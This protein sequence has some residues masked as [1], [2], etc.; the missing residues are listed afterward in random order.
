MS[1]T[2]TLLLG[3]FVTAVLVLLAVIDV[4]RRIVPNRIVLPATGIVL[5]VR[6]AL[7]PGEAPVYVL[8]ALL[9]AI[10]LFLPRLLSSA[11]IGMGDVKLG[12]LIGATLGW[13]TAPALALGFLVVF[14]VAFAIAIR[15]GIAA[16]RQTTLPLCPFLSFGALTI[17]IAPALLG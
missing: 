8:A 10:F 9:A 2:I 6:L 13:S 14:P 12:L 15:S 5:L 11:S 17:M 4:R 3:A 7:S 16:T 1:H